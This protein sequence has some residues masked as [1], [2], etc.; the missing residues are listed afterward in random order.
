MGLG[1]TNATSR[2]RQIIKSLYTSH[3]TLGGKK[4]KEEEKH[5]GDSIKIF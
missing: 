3:V 5:G 1:D 2:L 4:M